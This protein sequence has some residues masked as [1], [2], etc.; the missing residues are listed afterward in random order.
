MKW[1]SF[2]FTSA[3]QGVFP[4]ANGGQLHHAWQASGST[5]GENTPYYSLLPWTAAPQPMAAMSLRF[6]CDPALLAT[7]AY[8]FIESRGADS[9]SASP[10]EAAREALPEV[11]GFRAVAEVLKA[12]WRRVRPQWV[13]IRSPQ[14]GCMASGHRKQQIQTCRTAGLTV[15]GCA[16]PVKTRPYWRASILLK[17]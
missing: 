13:V 5:I 9:R 4:C 6:T 7:R 1:L 8:V 15:R 10:A 17:G 2:N 11:G 12:G 14:L 16:P 3:L